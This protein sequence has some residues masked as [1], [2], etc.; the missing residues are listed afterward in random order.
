MCLAIRDLMSSSIVYCNQFCLYKATRHYPSCLN[1]APLRIMSYCAT[2][3]E[4]PAAN[5]NNF[6][7][8]KSLLNITYMQMICQTVT[9][10]LINIIRLIFYLQYSTISDNIR[11]NP[12][13][14]DKIMS[15]LMYQKE[16][17]HI[18]WTITS[19][20]YEGDKRV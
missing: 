14:F 20:L 18:F 13:I 17:V 2:S 15:I 7:P 11:S 19:V 16:I 10:I 4:H 9:Y 3:D 8:R 6:P 12:T 1:S 5:F